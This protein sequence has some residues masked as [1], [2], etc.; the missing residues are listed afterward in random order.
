MRAQTTRSKKKNIY[1][2]RIGVSKEEFLAYFEKRRKLK[3]EQGRT[4]KEIEPGVF[5]K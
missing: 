3:D 2:P 5:I 4:Y 1:S